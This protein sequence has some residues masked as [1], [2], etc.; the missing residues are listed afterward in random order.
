M[1]V[2]E[3]RAAT[4]IEDPVLSEVLRVGLQEGRFVLDK[5]GKVRA[6]DF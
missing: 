2:R 6:A 4:P 1:E 5:G 3:L